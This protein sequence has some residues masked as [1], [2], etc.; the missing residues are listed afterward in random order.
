[1]VRWAAD[2]AVVGRR[3]LGLRDVRT[4]ANHRII[5]LLS[6]AAHIII[7][8]LRR[9]INRRSGRILCA[10]A[11]RSVAVGRMWSHCVIVKDA[12]GLRIAD[13]WCR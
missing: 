1:M 8:G 2:K 13:G 9:W 10:I 4:D 11:A 7:L 6:V 12:G 5:P 3:N